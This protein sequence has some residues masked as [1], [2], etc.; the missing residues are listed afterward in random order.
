MSAAH[1][2]SSVGQWLE[3]RIESSFFLLS[4]TCRR[5]NSADG[6]DSLW[7]GRLQLAAA[8]IAG[9]AC[10]PLARAGAS[11]ANTL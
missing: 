3:L 1:D 2:V 8:L 4:D 11:F 9:W 7:A 10:E 6:S 5:S